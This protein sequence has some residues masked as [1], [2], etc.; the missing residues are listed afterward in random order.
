MDADQFMTQLK[1]E[2][3][4]WAHNTVLGMMLA[5]KN[6]PFKALVGPYMKDTMVGA[7]AHAAAL[8]LDVETRLVE[9]ETWVTH[10]L[11]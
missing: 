10:Y 6:E 7:R 11:A 9:Y 1:E 2:V 8:N 5:M 3:A 4:N